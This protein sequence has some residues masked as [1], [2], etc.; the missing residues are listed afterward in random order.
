MPCRRPWGRSA[1]AALARRG[2]PLAP[3]DG[4][5]LEFRP[6]PLLAQV[7]RAELA[8]VEPELAGAPHRRAAHWHAR[9]REP[10]RALEH[11]LAARDAALA[12][13]IPLPL[14][15]AGGRSAATS[16]S[17]SARSTPTPGSRSPPPSTS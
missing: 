14:A 7:L 4:C 5:E 16:P 10:D 12:G 11:A 9:R 2:L 15:A 8:R 3:L 13:R 17:T 1:V 6:H